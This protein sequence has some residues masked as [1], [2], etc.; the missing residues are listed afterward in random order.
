MS[1]LYVIRWQERRDEFECL[2]MKNIVQRVCF[3]EAEKK[4]QESLVISQQSF[5]CR[6]LCDDI[7]NLQHFRPANTQ[8]GFFGSNCL[9]Q[10]TQCRLNEDNKS[11][12]D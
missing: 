12:I 1:Q 8:S 11:G 10:S 7:E 3:H 9:S 2:V 4:R 6:S 5:Y